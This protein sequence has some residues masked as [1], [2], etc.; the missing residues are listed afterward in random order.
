MIKGKLRQL[1]WLLLQ[2]SF[3]LYS[4]YIKVNQKHIY[5]SLHFHLTSMSHS[6]LTTGQIRKV[7]R[8]LQCH[9]LSSF[10]R[11]KEEAWLPGRTAFSDYHG[12]I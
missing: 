9:H 6:Q 1:L 5:P 4:L 7:R 12:Y 10:A 8:C 11:Q 2:T 3:F